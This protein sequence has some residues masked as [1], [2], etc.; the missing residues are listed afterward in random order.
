WCAERVPR[1]LTIIKYINKSR[2]PPRRRDVPAGGGQGTNA[3][4]RCSYDGSPYHGP[5]LHDPGPGG[6]EAAP[7][8]R[9]EGPGLSGTALPPGRLG[10]PP[11]P[12]RS[13]DGGA[14]QDPR[15]LRP[16]GGPPPASAQ[17]G[18]PAKARGDAQSSHG[19]T[20]CP[21]EGDPQGRTGIKVAGDRRSA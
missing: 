7:R 19:G 10:G 17:G 12:Q 14:L 13:A 5:G 21:G 3:L 16:T 11:G 2:S 18:T 9:E 6:R 20:A 8:Q 1:L 15:G 4:W